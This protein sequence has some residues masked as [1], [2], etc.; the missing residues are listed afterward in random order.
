MASKIASF[1]FF[2][3]LNFRV[4]T[5]DCDQDERKCDQKN[6]T[7]DNS[8]TGTEKIFRALLWEDGVAELSKEG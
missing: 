4:L 6:G 8:A 7:R 1:F 3:R 2:V 5:H